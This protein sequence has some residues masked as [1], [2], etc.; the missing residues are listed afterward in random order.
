[1]HLQ[2]VAKLFGEQQIP[3]KVLSTA[4]IYVLQL[5][6]HLLRCYSD[7]LLLYTTWEISLIK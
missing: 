4:E 5:T 7:V 6:L 1:M 2:R 3:A